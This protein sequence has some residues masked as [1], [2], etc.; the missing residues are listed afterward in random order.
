MALDGAGVLAAATYGKKVSD[1]VYLIDASTGK[2][3]KFMATGKEF[4]QPVFADMFLVLASGNNLTA[5]GP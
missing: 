1:G 4:S 3:I 2:V 5:Y